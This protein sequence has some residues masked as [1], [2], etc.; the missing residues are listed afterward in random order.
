MTT[1]NKPS[2]F[3]QVTRLICRE[4]SGIRLLNKPL[5]IR[6]ALDELI[7]HNSNPNRNEKQY[8]HKC[9]LISVNSFNNSQHGSFTITYFA[10]KVMSSVTIHI[11]LSR[12]TVK[13]IW[14][15]IYTLETEI[16][17]QDFLFP[18]CFFEDEEPVTP[19]IKRKKRVKK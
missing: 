1:L 2:Y 15:K 4:N 11:D 16:R 12:L 5:E 14:S 17:I 6:D 9:H 13:K 18:E 7:G 8:Y 10:H 19:P 3:T